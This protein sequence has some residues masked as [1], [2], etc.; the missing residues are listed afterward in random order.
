MGLR[1]WIERSW[2]NTESPPGCRKTLWSSPDKQD[3]WGPDGLEVLHVPMEAIHGLVSTGDAHG[4]SDTL[5]EIG[6]LFQQLL[7]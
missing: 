4:G 5:E 2:E 7:S 3:G 6:V 1:G